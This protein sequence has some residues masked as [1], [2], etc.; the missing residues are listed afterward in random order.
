M[1][2]IEQEIASEKPV[3]TVARSVAAAPT[4]KPGRKGI[5]IAAINFWI[6]ASLLV[7]LVSFIWISAVLRFVFPAPTKAAGWQL[8]GWTYD[9]WS[10]FQFACLCIMGLGVLIHVMM[11]W[12]WVCSVL[13]V[14]VLKTKN[15]I[16]DGMQTIYGVGVLIVLLHVIFAGIIA[17]NYFIVRPPM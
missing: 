10:D 1:E 2:T 7:I 4:P 12:N 17:A 5:S 16:D 6:D 14:H 13:T 8:Y 11:H 3:V 15:R 9:Q